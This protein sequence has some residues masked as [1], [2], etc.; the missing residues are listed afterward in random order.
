MTHDYLASLRLLVG[1]RPLLMVE[2]AILILDEHNRLL[3]MKRVDRLLG[4]VV[5]KHLVYRDS[6]FW[7]EPTA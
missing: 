4:V 2:A 7:K 6:I 3:L 5:R 1:H